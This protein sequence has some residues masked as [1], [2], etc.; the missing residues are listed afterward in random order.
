MVVIIPQLLFQTETNGTSPTAAA[1]ACAIASSHSHPH[2]G[3]LVRQNS[4]REEENL[5]PEIVIIKNGTLSR[6][7]TEE[8]ERI[9]DSIQGEVRIQIVL[10]YVF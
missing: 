10:S 3:K 8:T 2:P 1:S 7:C 9:G 5:T 6:S 4:V